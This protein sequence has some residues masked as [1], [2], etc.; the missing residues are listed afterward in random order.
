MSNSPKLE[1]VRYSTVRV[2]EALPWP[3]YSQSGQLMLERGS[4]VETETQLEKLILYGMFVPEEV[5]RSLD[6]EHE[7]AQAPDSEQGGKR[8]NPFA[9]HQRW[10]F[11]LQKSYDIVS[12]QRPEGI[13]IL[14][15]LV[16][17]LIDACDGDPDASLGFIHY[18]A[19]QPTPTQL[20]LFYGVLSRLIA[21]QLDFDKSRTW[22]LVAA[23]V[24]ANA[25][26]MPYQEKLNQSASALTPRL[27]E[28]INKHPALSATMLQRVGI[29]DSL[30][31]QIVEQH[32]ERPDGSGYPN[33]LRDGQILL[34]AQVVALVE[35]YAALVSARGYRRRS[36][37]YEALRKIREDAL[38]LSQRTLLDA[39]NMT[40]SEHPPGTFVQLSNGETAIVIR[41]G[42][43][44]QQPVLKAVLAK[45][46]NPYVT[47]LKRDP[48]DH[49]F[50]M[51]E[52]VFP[53]IW[54]KATLAS[55]WGYEQDS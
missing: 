13:V 9:D 12:Q 51:R 54:P 49:D 32:H 18:N 14:H 43:G 4:V 40:L 2:G 15:K 26:L 10:L 35:R 45:G 34:E 1:R 41:R 20:A 48:G 6:E 30:W 11:D 27:R 53:S 42:T 52:R 33:G 44:T 3:V 8:V 24:S 16:D 25:A 17:D 7:K 21:R 5:A 23:A 28:I 39:L 22:S 36:H 19:T 31:L 50:E 38:V 55:L 37:P 46:G 47:P 29:V